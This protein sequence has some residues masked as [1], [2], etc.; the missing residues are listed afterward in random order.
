MPDSYIQARVGLGNVGSYQVSGIPFA[1]SSIPC[2]VSSSAPTQVSFTTVTK[3]VVIK[4]TSGVTV[5][6][7]IGFSMNGVFDA[8]GEKYFFTLA[9]GE[10]YSSSIRCTSVFL[11]SDHGTIEASASVIAALT[12]IPAER[13]P[14]NWS[15]SVG[16]G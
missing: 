1:S 2:G 8:L 4:N 14:L 5:D 3:E 6:L 7:R 9:N 15:G 10:S 16:I 11:L 13:L 12:G